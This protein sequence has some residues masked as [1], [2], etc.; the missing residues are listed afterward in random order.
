MTSICEKLPGH[1]RIICQEGKRHANGEAFTMEERKA[2]VARYLRIP[3]SSFELA[4]SDVESLPSRLKK[5]DIGVIL[6]DIISEKSDGPVACGECKNE[7]FRLNYM[8]MEQVLKEK[9]ELAKRITGRAA[10]RAAKW[11]QRLAAKWA[12]EF[13]AGQIE[14]WIEEACE[15]SLTE[16]VRK[17]VE[18]TPRSPIV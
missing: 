8:P 10:E 9:S 1:L 17:H 12:P 16:Y 3:E 13:V 4:P 6:H 11:Y 5:T 15:K 18:F 7:M 2:V 14:G